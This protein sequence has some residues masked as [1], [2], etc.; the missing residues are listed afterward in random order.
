MKPIVIIICL[1]FPVY[2][3]AAIPEY[4]APPG[5]QTHG[6]FWRYHWYR[7]GMDYGNPGHEI[8]F[9]INSPEISLNPT[10]GKRAE[11]RENGMMLIRAD[12][13]L[14]RLAGAE[15]YAEMWGGHPGTANKRV[16][17]NGRSI[18]TL[19]PV[20]T[21]EGHCTYFYPA[22]PLK[23]TDLVTGFNAVQFAVDQGNAFW[24]HCLIDNAAI[25]AALTDKHPD[26]VKLGL[27]A[28]SASVLVSPVKSGEGFGLSLDTVPTASSSIAFVE[29]FGWYCGYD[30]NGNR[31]RNDWHGFTKNRAAQAH[32]GS[33]VTPPYLIRWDTSLLPVQTDTAVRAVVH[34]TSNPDLVYV[35]SAADNLSVTHPDGVHVILV[36]PQDLPN[37][38][39]SRAGQMKTCS[40]DLDM[41]P[42]RIEK[43][44]L[45]CVTWTGGSGTIRNYFTL[46]GK[47]FPV[48]EGDRHELIYTRLDVEPMILRRG[49]NPVELLSDTEHHGIEVILPG[50]ALMIRFK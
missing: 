24:G 13:D 38:F 7:Q 18:Y 40:F 43:A 4:N 16:S 42:A 30:E 10:F 9:R 25:R 44:V 22:I 8:R 19:P 46:N 3:T 2:A 20:G 39:W 14:F 33:A 29:Y 11:A 27:D 5:Q 15:L 45:H 35:T 36:S 37:P 12:E 32:L 1:L 21:E 47:H 17:V 34:F 48:A 26:L 49:R 6:R 50:P 31:L 23:R 28:F 41:D